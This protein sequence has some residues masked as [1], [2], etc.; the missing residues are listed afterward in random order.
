VENKRKKEESEECHIPL[1]LSQKKGN[2]E[3]RRL[4]K[5]SP[6]FLKYPGRKRLH[7]IIEYPRL[8]RFHDLFHLGFRSDHE[9]RK[10][11]EL[12]AGPDR[13]Q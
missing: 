2:L 7:E 12:L 11:F 5:I 9:H 1:D 6:I 10:A 8:Y 3:Q 4:W 13:M